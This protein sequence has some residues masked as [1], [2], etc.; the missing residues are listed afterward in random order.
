MNTD[1]HHI[2][3]VPPLPEPLPD[4]A[5]VRYPAPLERHLR[6]RSQV[7]PPLEPMEDEVTAVVD[8]SK[9]QDR[10]EELP[11]HKGRRARVF[12]FVVL[13]GVV[14]GLGYVGTGVVFALRDAWIAPINL[15]PDNDKVIALRLRHRQHLME[16][17]KLQ[18]ELQKVEGDLEATRHSAKRLR[19]LSEEMVQVRRYNRSSRARRSTVLDDIRVNLRRQQR[20]LR[21]LLETSREA[22]GE[23]RAQFKSGLIDKAELAQRRARVEQIQ[24]AHQEN[25]RQLIETMSQKENTDLELEAWSDSAAKADEEALGILPE[26]VAHQQERARVELEVLRLEADEKALAAQAR[27]LR[28]A[29]REMDAL[30]EEIQAR[31]LYRAMAA[32][33]NIA[34]IP[35]AQL[36]D[37]ATG[38][39]VVACQWLLFDCRT[40]GTVAEILPGEV[41]TQ[42]PWG[43]MARG[44]YAILDMKD[45]EAIRD[46]ALRIRR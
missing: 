14:L 29:A 33:T 5:T 22:L 39:G 19:E 23:A 1:R 30:L 32:D 17:E 11:P 31:P 25:N 42:D 9:V 37:V 28:T 12:S 40:V 8:V 16:R 15:S 24:L 21:S 4:E 2:H 6:R 13:I 44:Q 43:E 18:V 46:Q 34:F 7:L 10:P 20:L 36:D 41:V 38:Q 35:Y 3:V 27:I 45:A 26:V